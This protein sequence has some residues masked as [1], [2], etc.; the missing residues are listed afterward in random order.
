MP[1]AL[2][3]AEDEK[4]TVAN[5]DEKQEAASSTA[6]KA[7]EQ[8]SLLD[9]VTAALDKTGDEASPTSAEPD[10]KSAEQPDQETAEPTDKPSEGDEDDGFTEA[11]R[12]ALSEKTHN[13]M[14]KLARDKKALSVEVESLRGRAENFDKVAHF[15]A[16][17]NLTAE[18]VDNTLH[19]AGL[20]R[21]DPAAALQALEPIVQQ[22]RVVTGRVLSDDLAEDVR[23]GFG[24][25]PRGGTVSSPRASQAG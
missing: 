13:R 1:D 17:R 6:D 23:L 18:D 2:A 22:L 20:I 24:T 4:S 3:G 25:K 14:K 21:N 9:A 10:P 8:P 19:I 12:S 5:T 15:V 11:E 16:E 7:K